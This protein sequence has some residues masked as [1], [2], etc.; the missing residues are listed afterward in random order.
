MAVY[1]LLSAMG[2]LTVDHLRLGIPTYDPEAYFNAVRNAPATR[3]VQG[4]QLDRVLRS[5]GQQ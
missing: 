5:I 1:R 4:D 3:S 2:L